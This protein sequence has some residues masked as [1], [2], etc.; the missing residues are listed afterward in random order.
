MCL[1][2]V[3]VPTTNY[4]M[5]KK[6]LKTIPNFAPVSNDAPSTMVA[7]FLAENKKHMRSKAVKRLE[8]LIEDLILR[9]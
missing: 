7:N 8:T 1:K 5:L 4:R 2:G 3:E 9:G 6:E